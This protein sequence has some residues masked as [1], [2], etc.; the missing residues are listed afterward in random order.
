MAVKIAVV[1]Y[2]STGHNYR[3]AKAAMAGA[4]EAGAEVRL[5]KAQELA[6]KEVIEGSPDW[7]KHAEETADIPVATGADLE[8]A[9]GFIFGTPSR[10][11]GVASQLKQFIDTTGG[12]WAQGKMANKVAAGFTSAQNL[13]GGQE[14]TLLSL[15]TT[16][17]HWGCFIVPPGFTDQAVFDSGGNP[18]GLSATAGEPGQELDEAV[19][20]GA[21]YLGKR[22]A[23]VASWIQKGRNA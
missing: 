17:Y 9:D 16:F 8:W 2:S 11:G 18:Y 20:R 10:F 23:T 22:V 1:Y 19:L 5:R 4:E 3:L 13:H 12:L 7:K 14:V 6:P 21:R 15:Y